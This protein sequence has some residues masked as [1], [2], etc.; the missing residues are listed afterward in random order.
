MD[1]RILTVAETANWLR[2][3]E[4]TIRRMCEGG[5]LEGAFRAGD[6]QWRIPAASVAQYIG[7]R[8]AEAQARRD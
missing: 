3:S 1:E 5:D 7:R 2:L 8:Q 4:Q 6:R